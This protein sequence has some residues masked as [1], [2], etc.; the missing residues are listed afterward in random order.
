MGKLNCSWECSHIFT[1]VVFF[2]NTFIS[3]YMYRSGNSLLF[4]FPEAYSGPYQIFM[5][6]VFYENNERLNS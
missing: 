4:L 5:L 3:L 6:K 1:P 2:K